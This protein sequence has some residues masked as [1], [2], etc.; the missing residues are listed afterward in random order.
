MGNTDEAEVPWLRRDACQGFL[1]AEIP[2]Y[3]S[4]LRSQLPE[5]LE[6]ACVRKVRTDKINPGTLCRQI[7]GEPGLMFTVSGEGDI[8][9]GECQPLLCLRIPPDFLLFFLGAETADSGHLFPTV[10]GGD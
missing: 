7:N 5:L 4:K 6:D 2:F 1:A 9:L 8:L 3:K 10:E